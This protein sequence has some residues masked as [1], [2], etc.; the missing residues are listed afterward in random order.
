MGMNEL[1]SSNVN[2]LINRFRKDKY[3]ADNEINVMICREC[4]NIL[5]TRINTTAIETGSE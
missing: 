5:I 2:Y 1:L 3:Y 4:K